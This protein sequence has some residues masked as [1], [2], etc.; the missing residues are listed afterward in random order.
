MSE[1][2]IVVKNL[3]KIYKLY[4][5]KSDQVKELFSFKKSYHSDFYALKDID[6]KLEKGG[7]LGI[8]GKNGS[9]KSTLLKIITGVLTPTIGEVE[10]NGKVSALLE[11]GA[12]FNNEYTGLENIYLQ[13]TL[14]GFSKDEMTKKVEEIVDFA[15]IGEHINQPVKSYSSGMFVRLA[16]AIAISIEPEILIVDEALSVGDIRFQRKCFRKIEEFKKNKTFVFVSH[17]L[18]TV[19]KF[20]DRVIWINEGVMQRDGDPIEVTKEFRAYMIEAKFEEHRGERALDQIVEIRDAKNQFDPIPNDV[21]IMGDEKAE[22]LG[23]LM[24]DQ[25]GNK[26]TSVDANEKCTICFRIKANETIDEAI[27]GFT[28]KDR[29][30]SI[31]FQTNTFVIGEQL[32][33]IENSIQN[34]SFTFTMPKLIDG[35]YTVSPAIASGTMSYHVQH[36]WLYDV[37]VLQVLNKQSI[38]L[39]GY[40]YLDDVVFSVDE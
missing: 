3:T 7:S 32:T 13:G 31:I 9:G 10:V 8:V 29:L 18:N 40:I 4:N 16:F 5:K 15:D 2:A 33:L 36:C 35:Y 11:L 22:F 27:I 17:D 6:F 1:N 24:L 34:V 39:E 19:A 26:G 21:S 20:C 28:I 38:N 30:G 23:T 37:M 14:M 25:D 12:G